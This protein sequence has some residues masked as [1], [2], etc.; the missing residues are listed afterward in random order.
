MITAALVD[1]SD[2]YSRT[3]NPD[4]DAVTASPSIGVN[5]SP[6]GYLAGHNTTV[7]PDP[8]SLTEG[9]CGSPAS[10]QAADCFSGNREQ[11]EGKGM[12]LQRMKEASLSKTEGMTGWRV[13]RN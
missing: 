1:I 13:W 4:Q 6:K 11:F 12:F 9:N 3:T 10:D 2:L 8:K 7:V 5:G